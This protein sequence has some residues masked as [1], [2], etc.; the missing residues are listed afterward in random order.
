MFEIESN[1]DLLQ[2]G[3]LLPLVE[4]FYTIQGEGFHSGKPAYFI[5]LGGCDI[6]CRWCDAKFTWN[7]KN[8]PPVE[9]KKIVERASSFPAK[10]AVVT[11]GEPTLYPLGILCNELKNKNIQTFIETSGA[12]PLTGIWDW[13]CLS[14]KYQQPPLAEIFPIANELK[15]IIEKIDDLEWAEENAAKV[16]KDCMLF[17]QA[18]WSKYSEITPI[19]VEYAKQN[20]K[21][22]ISIQTHK[23]MNI[24]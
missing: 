4:D 23:F 16:S 8:H 17:L 22:N 11:G 3:N 2:N 21:W 24:P 13:I 19:I 12:Y 9:A 6:C 1:I 18:E 14:P 20:P 10:A 7:P 5:R 15:V